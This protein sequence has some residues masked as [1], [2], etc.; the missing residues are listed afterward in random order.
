MSQEQLLDTKSANAF[1]DRMQEA[2]TA[3]QD[4]MVYTQAVQEEFAN[5]YKSASP[6]YSVRDQ[7][8]VNAFHFSTTRPSK[9]LSRR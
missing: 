8:F 6:L 2:L 4:S 1:A 7:V 9:K 3:A 5:R